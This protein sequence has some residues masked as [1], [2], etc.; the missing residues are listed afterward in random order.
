V[1]LVGRQL[2]KTDGMSST[3]RPAPQRLMKTGSSL[4]VSFISLRFERVDNLGAYRIPPET[5]IL[6]QSDFIIY[7]NLS[8]LSPSA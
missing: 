1:I 3:W 7:R 6:I 8:L 5:G 2:L 4:P